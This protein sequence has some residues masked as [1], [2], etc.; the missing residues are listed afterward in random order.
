MHSKNFVPEQ[1]PFITI[2]H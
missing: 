2:T 1:L